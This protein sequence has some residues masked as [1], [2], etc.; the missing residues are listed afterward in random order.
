[1]GPAFFI[2]ALQRFLSTRT[3]FHL[4][5]YSLIPAR[6]VDESGACPLALLL[7]S[8]GVNW[9]VKDEVDA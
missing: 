3:L 4:L 6:N 9:D 1:M 8:P 5:L 2:F 7:L